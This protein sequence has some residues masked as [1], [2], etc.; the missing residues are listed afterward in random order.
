MMFRTSGSQW[1]YVIGTQAQMLRMYGWFTYMKGE[2][3]ATWTRGYGLV[4]IPRTMEHL[5]RVNIHNRTFLDSY[6]KLEGV[7]MQRS[8]LR[9]RWCCML[10]LPPSKDAGSSPP[11][12]HSILVGGLDPKFWE[13][14]SWYCWLLM[15]QKSGGPPVG[16]FWNFVMINYQPQL[17]SPDFFQQYVIG[18]LFRFSSLK[19]ISLNKSG[20]CHIIFPHTHPWCSEP[21][22]CF[23][24]GG[25][26]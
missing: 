8:R 10:E 11:G 25:S 23:F 7:G 26:L 17:T 13:R 21:N 3:T 24:L 20:N 5:G 19:W 1:G 15:V 12:W 14:W 4:N 6:G 16:C 22:T 18:P 9:H 2:K